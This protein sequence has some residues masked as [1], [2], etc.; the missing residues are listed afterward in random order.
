MIPILTHTSKQFF[1]N[2][3]DIY[4]RVIV[5]VFDG[6]FFLNSSQA[7]KKIKNKLLMHT[8]IK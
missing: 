6:R 5:K 3:D 7:Q 4:T 8:K 2:N 1:A